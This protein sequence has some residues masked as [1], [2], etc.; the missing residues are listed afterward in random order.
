MKCDLCGNEGTV[1]EA[2]HKEKGKVMICSDCWEDL[3]DN[4]QLV[5][6]LTGEGGAGGSCAGC[7]GCR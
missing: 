4:N 7:S 3:Y 5:S 6:G 2:N 1:L